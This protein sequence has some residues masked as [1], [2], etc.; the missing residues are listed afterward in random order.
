MDMHEAAELARALA[1]P[2]AFLIAIYC[3]RAELRDFMN[4]L[5]QQI[6]KA[7]SISIGTKGLDIKLAAVNT[8][9][10]AI[11]AAQEQAKSSAARARRS[12]AKIGAI[13]KQLSGLAHEYL[14][15][16]IA[17]YRE[18]VRRKNE[19]AREMGDLALEGNVSRKLLFSRVKCFA[20]SW[21]GSV[22]RILDDQEHGG[23]ED[24]RDLYIIID[25]P[26]YASIPDAQEESSM[27]TTV[28]SHP[29]WLSLIR[30]TPAYPFL[31]DFITTLAKAGYRAQAILPAPRR[32]RCICGR[33]PRHCSRS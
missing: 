2:L 32:P 29:A 31:D 16:N 28:F 8:R 21:Q 9:V 23:F 24:A 4:K 17:D 22:R 33:T 5:T 18:R 27:L 1:W 11:Q 7:A 3:L 19:I 26:P 10:T 12:Q 6:S 14:N 20:E 15:V 30:S 25:A 13:P